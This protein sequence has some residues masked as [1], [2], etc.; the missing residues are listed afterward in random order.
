MA[1]RSRV[2]ASSRTSQLILSLICFADQKN[3]VFQANYLM[4]QFSILKASCDDLECRRLL[5]DLK[6]SFEKYNSKE[7]TEKKILVN[8]Y[9]GAAISELTVP[10]KKAINLV[11]PEW[12]D[13]YPEL[14][15][16]VYRQLHVECAYGSYDLYVTREF[17]SDDAM[18]T[19]YSVESNEGMVLEK[20]SGDFISETKINYFDSEDNPVGEIN[21]ETGLGFLFIDSQKEEVTDCKLINF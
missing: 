15:L 4:G 19:S 5:I 2:R 1:K 9:A 12:K 17:P 10:M 8:V 16:R 18:F 11:Y 21:F 7:S 6:K 20:L 3:D 13:E 14:N